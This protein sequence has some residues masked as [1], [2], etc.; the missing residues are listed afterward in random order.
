MIIGHS[1]QWEYLKKAARMGKIPHAFLFHGE[2][3]LGKKKVAL[4]LAKLIC[5]QNSDFEK[6]PCGKCQSCLRIEKGIFPDFFLVE[7]SAMAE[8]GESIKK[9]NSF[10]AGKKIQISQ[11]RRLKS[12]FALAAYSA[13]FKIAIIDEAHSMNLDAQSSFLK[14]LEEPKGDSL[15]IL[16]TPFP[17]MLLPTIVSRTEKLRFS[18]VPEEEIKKYL[19][20]KGVSPEKEEEILYF[21]E[22]KPGEALDFFSSRQKLEEH[23]ERIKEINRLLKSDIFTRFEYAKELSRDF[24]GTLSILDFWLGYFRKILIARETGREPEEAGNFKNYPSAKL[25]E[26]IRAIEKTGYLLSNTNAS[27][28]LALEFLMLHFD[29]R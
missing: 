14:L 7:P 9:E 26:I 19:R 1:L 3:G 12:A 23:K 22:G 11:I 27:P 20:K 5:C 18:R 17:G 2:K 4:E 15:F 24:Q 25:K 28:I 21:S 8:K 16:I 13:P 10:S 29:W 6:R